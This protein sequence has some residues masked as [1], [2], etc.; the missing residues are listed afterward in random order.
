MVCNRLRQM[1]KAAGTWVRSPGMDDPR[2]YVQV[3]DA[4]RDDISRGKL[5]TGDPAPS[6]TH[7]TQEHGVARQTAAKALHLLEEEGLLQKW[8]GLGYFVTG[9]GA[10]RTRGRQR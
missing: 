6:I 5:H 2:R 8:P 7:L 3:A 1:I 10:S 9:S 4:I